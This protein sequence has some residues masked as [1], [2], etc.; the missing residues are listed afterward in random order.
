MIIDI[1]FIL[2]MIL[3][4]YKGLSKGL[5]LGIFSL[6]AFIIGLAAALKLSV[7]VAGYLKDSSGAL[8]KWLPLISFLLVFIAV[9]LLVGLVARLIK[10]TMQIAMLGW[11]DRLGGMILYVAIY[12]IIF[13]IFLFFAE[14][15]FLLQ[16]S[17]VQ[18]SKVYLYVAPWGPKVMDNLGSIIPL[19]KDMFA[20]LQDFFG[21]L[22][23]KSA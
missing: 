16:P 21:N 6:L 20:E 15:L 8:S 23:K 17:T 11:L 1:A 5:V 12:T 10:K 2:V 9:I 13:S 19:F 7:V 18:D 22:A 4:L 3:A 14:K